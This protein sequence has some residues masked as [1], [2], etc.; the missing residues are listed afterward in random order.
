MSR[1]METPEPKRGI[2]PD[3]AHL[4]KDVS[5]SLVI[6][7]GAVP[8]GMATALLAGLAPIHG[9]YATV[10]GPFFGGL[11]SS[12]QRMMITTTS[13]TALAVGQSLIGLPAEAMI[14][15][16]L[17]ITLLGGFFMI[18]AGVFKLGFL[19]RFVSHSVMTGFLTGVAVI[20]ILGQI[21]NF[22][23]YNSDAG[24]KVAEAVDAV[25]HIRDWD[26]STLFIGVLALIIV[27][28][29]DRTR[30]RNFSRLIGIVIP[31]LL[32]IAVN[33]TSVQQVSDIA[34]I[35]RGLPPL[36]LPQLSYLTPNVITGALALAII[37]LIQGAGVSQSSPN[38]DGSPTNQNRDFAGQG[39][40][41][42]ASSLLNG[43]P[44]GGSV[45]DT[46]L[47][48]SAG[49]RTRFSIVFTG[50]WMVLFLTFFPG[51]VSQVAMPCLAAI[52]ILSGI[53]AINLREAVWTWRTGWSSRLTIAV[54]F[55]AT[56]VFPIQV[57]V[58]FGAILSALIY[59]SQLAADVTVVQVKRRDDGKQIEQ[60][61]APVLPSR[62]I[63]QLNIYGS[64]FYAG[65]RTL[66]EKLPSAKGAQQPVVILQLRGT[67]HIGSTF[68]DVVQDYGQEIAQ[69]GGR[70]YLVGLAAHVYQQL[71]NTGIIEENTAI[72]MIQATE[73]LGESTEQAA[74][75]A[76]AWLNRDS[77]A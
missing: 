51:L 48:A 6:A 45:G 32:V 54:T 57:A 19:T 22:T 17:L 47:G 29:L 42:V 21:G 65:A 35:P 31:T 64:V 33:L 41:N 30:L 13:A 70:L 40:A 24:G 52:L 38:L 66:E 20:I 2:F 10:A 60:A 12:T 58:A 15:T 11:T 14:P 73:V 8:D 67:S 72:R 76:L 59:L 34:A 69:A 56:I 62:E 25:L 71:H 5:A 49:S 74:N 68:V 63:V 53:G 26:F 7:I 39:I 43:M 9:L 23:G 36:D 44:V 46:A 27:V 28:T 75:D 55:V 50:L 37:A 4:G 1:L 61:P 18:L 77:S 3:R 16:M